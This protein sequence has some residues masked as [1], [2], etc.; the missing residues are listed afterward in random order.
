[1]NDGKSSERQADGR[2][3]L[4]EQTIS[5]TGWG[6]LDQGVGAVVQF[7]VGIVLARLLPPEDFGLLGLALIVVGFGALFVKLGLG[8]ALIQRQDLTERHVRVAFTV[9]SLAGAVLSILV[10]L[11]APLAAAI[12]EDP[13]VEPVVRV[14]ALSFVIGGLQVSG[15]ALLQK[16]L[17]FK[18]L[19]KI[20]ASTHLAYG[21]IAISLAL[22]D[23][24][25]WSLVWGTLGQ[26]VITLTLTYLSVR[27]SVR[28]LLAWSEF[29]QLAVFGGGMSAAA[30][31]NYFAT[32]GD[33]FIVG[34]VLGRRSLGLYT[35]A[36]S[37]MQMPTQRFV[38]V[39]SNVLFPAASRLQNDVEGFRKAFL[40]S[41]ETIAFVTLPVMVL[42]VAVA[43]ELVVGVYGPQWVGAV[44]PLQLL[45]AFGVFRAMYNGAAAFLRAKGWVY[46]ILLC[47]VIYGTVLFV[48]TWLAAV[49]VGLEGAALAVGMSILVMWLLMMYYGARAAEVRARSLVVT[50]QGGGV[51]GLFVGV[52]VV[53]ARHGLLALTSV[54][55]IVLAGELLAGGVVA[56][57]VL[58][59]IPQRL[60]RHIPFEL[61][62]L[63]EGN[64]PQAWGP[65]YRRLRER[66]SRGRRASVSH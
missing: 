65:R 51:L 2:V 14:L 26:R 15:E 25:V 36:Y 23:F 63:V 62:K 44:V 42:M 59:Y 24:G 1:M 49:Y 54:P 46:R 40:R 9:S 48:S 11:G 29:R 8:P 5:S 47:Q 35:R 3:S 22:L 4:R 38:S 31:F 39:I 7:A 17:A 20:N 19:F 27:H 30:F 10:A 61:L 12:L 6:L 55:L 13:G 28:P 58:W 53:A 43:P 66:F 41:M 18:R 57:L 45:G 64:V 50:L 37:L 33:Y 52:A 32:Q 16:D 34:R 56:L 60:L 21:A